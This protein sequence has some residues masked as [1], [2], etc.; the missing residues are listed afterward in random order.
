MF[1]SEKMKLAGHVARRGRSWN[2][3]RFFMRNPEE[4]RPLGRPR[5]TVL[6]WI[7]WDAMGWI[8]L[9]LDRDTRR[10]LLNT[11]VNLPVP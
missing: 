4:K 10:A 9:A 1:T 5:K 11:A 7:E 8:N 6:K 3:Y 2:A